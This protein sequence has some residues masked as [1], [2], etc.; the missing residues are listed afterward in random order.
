MILSSTPTR[1]PFSLSLSNPKVQTPSILNCL[2]NHNNIS[3]LLLLLLLTVDLTLSKIVSVLLGLNA[4][5]AINYHY[6]LQLKRC[7]S[8]CRYSK[9]CCPVW[10][11]A[12]PPLSPH[13]V[14]RQLFLAKDTSHKETG[15]SRPLLHQLIIILIG[16]LH[17]NHGQGRH[18]ERNKE[19]T[20]HFSRN[21]SCSRQTARRVQRALE[22]LLST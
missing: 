6:K 2:T 15:C 1:P 20:T 3:V 14:P 22:S 8:C 18:K 21:K 9:C 10:L 7:C 12:A 19:E 17:D 5:P 16:V 13:S 11:V 4:A